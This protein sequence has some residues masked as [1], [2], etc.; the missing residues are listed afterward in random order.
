MFW[1]LFFI[2]Q[3]YA[4]RLEETERLAT[5]N[6]IKIAILD[7]KIDTLVKDQEDMGENIKKIVGYLME[8]N[9]K[10]RNKQ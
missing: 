10:R 3:G 8:N 2:G 9:K 5:E 6:K 7:E 4:Q 1:L